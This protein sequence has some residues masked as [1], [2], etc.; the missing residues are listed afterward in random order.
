M[1]GRVRIS[2]LIENLCIRLQC[3]EAMRKALRNEKL[4]PILSGKFDRFMLV[5][6]LGSASGVNC[7]VQNTSS[8]YPSKFMMR[9]ELS[10]EM[11]PA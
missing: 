10:L 8:D 2:D 4:V 6:C 7:D 1:E 9:E 3:H 11:E 5:K